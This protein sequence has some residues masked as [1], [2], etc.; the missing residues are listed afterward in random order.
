M[1]PVAKFQAES[2][3]EIEGLKADTDLQGLSRIWLREVTAHKYG[4]HFT[5]MGRPIIQVPQDVMAMQELIWRIKPEVIVET[6]VAH[7]GSLIFSASMLELIGGEG[8]VIGV[9]IDIRAHNRAAIESHPMSKRI[10]LI[11]GSSVDEDIVR[12]VHGQCRGKRALVCL[13][14]NHTHDHVLRE[15]HAYSPLVG[16]GSYVVVFDTAIEDLPAQYLFGRSWGKGNSPKS[17]V[18]EFLKGNDRFRIDR[19][20]DAKLLISVAPEGYLECV[21]DPS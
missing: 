7:G 20:M 3:A 14:S 11:Q 5:W 2:A 10:T 6:G 19:E 1:D 12:Q 13:D 21:K 8:R 15:L 9:D 17:A 18:W 4:Y 16:K